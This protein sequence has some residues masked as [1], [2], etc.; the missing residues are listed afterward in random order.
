MRLSESVIMIALVFMRR[1]KECLRDVSSRSNVCG[2]TVSCL[3]T[4]HVLP[5]VVELLV[6]LVVFLDE[7]RMRRR[8]VG[9]L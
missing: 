6:L 2:Q 7:G 4:Q 3:I 1:L 9:Q 8:R 5:D